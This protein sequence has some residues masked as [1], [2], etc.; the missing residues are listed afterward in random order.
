MAA[1]YLILDLLLSCLQKNVSLK[2]YIKG[3]ATKQCLP[4]LFILSLLL[5][6]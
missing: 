1:R 6:V 4:S 2:K 3:N 5:L